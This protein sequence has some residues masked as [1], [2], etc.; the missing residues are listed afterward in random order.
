[1]LRHARVKRFSS[2]NTFAA[3][4]DYIY[5]MSAGRIAAVSLLTRTLLPFVAPAT[6]A[7]KPVLDSAVAGSLLRASQLLL[8]QLTSVPQG[9]RWS[10]LR[11]LRTSLP[12]VF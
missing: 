2:R 5:H 6:C 8:R 7:S 1:M 4:K 10:V 9:N 11:S 3:S 12:F